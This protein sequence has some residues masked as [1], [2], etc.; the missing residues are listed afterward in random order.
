M[1]SIVTSSR[2]LH[3]ILVIREEAQ[4]DLVRTLIKHRGW[5]RYPLA[6]GHGFYAA[7]PARAQR[8]LLPGHELL[9]TACDSAQ[10]VRAATRRNERQAGMFDFLCRAHASGHRVRICIESGSDNVLADADR[11]ILAGTVVK[12]DH[13]DHF[14]AR[15]FPLA[16]LEICDI[17]GNRWQAQIP[18]GL[19][20]DKPTPGVGFRATM[21][22]VKPID[23]TAAE[24]KAEIK[25]KPT[26]RLPKTT[27]RLPKP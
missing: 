27:K 20:A 3:E 17:N 26:K 8:H 10:A 5:K 11:D 25:V 1:T 22:P 13:R 18:A 12:R 4:P 21:E 14:T 19:Y 6:C 7:S 15:P 9:C 24:V 23:T 16:E 2:P